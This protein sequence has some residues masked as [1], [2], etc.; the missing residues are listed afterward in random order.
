MAH[1]GQDSSG[2]CRTFAWNLFV[3]HHV[4][5]D[6][7]VH[8]LCSTSAANTDHH[9]ALVDCIKCYLCCW[10]SVDLV[11]DAEKANIIFSPTIA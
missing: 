6:S 4:G 9:L 1:P 2:E 11:A 8:V 10:K 5:A 7:F 3:G